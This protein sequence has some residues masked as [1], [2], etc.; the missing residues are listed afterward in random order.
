MGRALGWLAGSAR[1]A[2]VGFVGGSRRIRLRRVA[3]VYVGKFSVRVKGFGQLHDALRGAVVRSGV[4]CYA[5][6]V[7]L[8]K[9]KDDWVIFNKKKKG[10]PYPQGL[11]ASRGPLVGLS[12]HYVLQRARASLTP[13]AS[14]PPGPTALGEGKIVGTTG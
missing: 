8:A 11:S 3:C 14:C 6:A 12:G 4:R 2:R 1:R 13:G 10:G 9:H 7:G 5:M